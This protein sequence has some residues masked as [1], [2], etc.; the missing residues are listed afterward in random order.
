MDCEVKN[1]FFRWK[2]MFLM[3][4]WNLVFIWG[5]KLLYRGVEWPSFL[6]QW[7][8]GKD[9]S[10]SF[11]YW[12]LRTFGLL[13][14]GWAS[15]IPDLGQERKGQESPRVKPGLRWSFRVSKC[16]SNVLA[17]VWHRILVPTICRF[18]TLHSQ[19][20]FTS[21]LRTLSEEN[22]LDYPGGPI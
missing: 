9:L 18:V 1:W 16:P 7:F 3:F 20:N 12:N 4:I 19:K 13:N 2:K 8:S 15:K 10:F 17:N 14:Y 21:R 5:K 6:W 22:S 11:I